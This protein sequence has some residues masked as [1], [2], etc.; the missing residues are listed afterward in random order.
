MPNIVS[1]LH[2]LHDVNRKLLNQ[3]GG[4]E[5]VLYRKPASKHHYYHPLDQPDPNRPRHWLGSLRHIQNAQ[6]RGDSL[7]A[8]VGFG[9]VVGQFT[10]GLKVKNLAAPLMFCDALLEEDEDR[11]NSV[12]M[13]MV[14]ESAAL[15]YDLL[16]LFVGQATEDD[17]DEDGNRLPQTGVGGATLAVFTEVENDIERWSN[18]VNPD[19]RFNLSA[20]T[21]AMNYIR[22][23]VPEFRSVSISPTPYDHKL[24]DALV[25]RRPPVFFAHRYF[26]VAPAAGELTTVTALASL[27]RQSE[28]SGRNA[29]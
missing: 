15:N 6:A 19:A 21:Q 3:R 1:Y 10:S 23:S 27:I 16:T 14:W 5:N 24:L 18:D 12:R 28:G 8:L 25:R 11:P 22:A 17:P 26:F 2:Y 13:R 4:L 20:Q 7:R 9:L 29:V